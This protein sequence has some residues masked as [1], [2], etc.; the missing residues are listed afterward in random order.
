MKTVVVDDGLQY[1]FKVMGYRSGNELLELDNDIIRV[2]DSLSDNL[3][4][5][6]YGKIL[7]NKRKIIKVTREI[8]DNYFDFHDVNYIPSVVSENIRRL[9]FMGVWDQQMISEQLGNYMKMV[10]PYEIP[11]NYSSDA[12][13]HKHCFNDNMCF[14]SISLDKSINKLLF[15]CYGHE[16]VHTQL[17]S[18]KGVV[19]NYHNREVLSIFV[20]DLISY[21]KDSSGALLRNILLYRY[22]DLLQCIRYLKKESA[23]VNIKLE[24]SIFIMSTLKA[25][26]LFNIYINSSTHEREKILQGIQNVFDGKETVEDFLDRYNITYNNSK[27]EEIIVKQLKKSL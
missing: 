6:K 24:A 14:S 16:L 12:L 23:S 7:K 10:S 4:E 25:E 1:K 26:K 27:N 18:Q 21:E 17:D 3:D 5:P 20:E 9:L 15:S 19:T 2:Y 11:I 8:L 22:G 13:V